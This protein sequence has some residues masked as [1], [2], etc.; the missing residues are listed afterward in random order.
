MQNTKQSQTLEYSG[1]VIFPGLLLVLAL[2]YHEVFLA[3]A[4]EWRGGTY[5][6]GFLAL[7]ISGYFI[8][9]SRTDLYQI[10]QPTSWWMLLVIT[11]AGFI[12][13]LAS[14]ANVQL[15]QMFS[16]IL[17][18]SSAIF[19]LY[20]W[21]TLWKLRVPLLSLILVLPVWNFLQIPL[22]EISSSVTFIGLDL[23]GIPVL[24]EGFRFTVPG[25][26]F[27]IEEACSGLGFFLSSCLL[28]LLYIHINN[29]QGPRAVFFLLFAV[30][31]S[32]VSNWI[33]ILTIM[34]VG[35]Y[36]QMEHIIVQDHLT[37]GWILYSVMLIPFFLVGHFFSNQQLKPVTS[38]P[39]RISNLP[40]TKPSTSRTRVLIALILALL[41]FPIVKLTEPHSTAR[42]SDPDWIQNEFASIPYVSPSHPFLKWEPDFKG[43]DYQSIR[44]SKIGNKDI[45]SLVVRYDK[46]EQGREL[47]YVR[48][49][50]YSPEKWLQLGKQTI[51]TN[52]DGRTAS[53]ILLTLEGRSGRKRTILYWYLIGNQITSSP[54]LAKL[55]EVK[56]IITGNTTAYLFAIAADMNQK[57]KDL[58][59]TEILRLSSELQSRLLS[60]LQNDQKA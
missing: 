40:E 59:L 28:G 15:V 14:L 25:G 44:Q 29:V 26:Q 34:V 24:R 23:L 42:P 4:R 2:G 6:H 13:W 22:Q 11:G 56:G 57:E 53:H 9:Q 43:A 7:L 12:W 41:L 18:V 52:H 48:N 39:E 17:L 27:L 8:W 50:L 20:G 21:G 38:P 60:S 55:Y 49:R 1:K 5:S 35:N 16:L 10:K 32:L 33:R 30:A 58:D 51:Q 45:L 47:I 46:Q 37:F 3:I 54:L 19:Y 36:T 31:L